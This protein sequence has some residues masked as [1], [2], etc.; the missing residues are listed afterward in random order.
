MRSAVELAH[1]CTAHRAGT[2][3]ESPTPIPA[4][5]RSICSRQIDVPVLSAGGC[6]NVLVVTGIF[7][8]D[9]GGP[10]SYVPVM[11]TALQGKGHA[12]VS[13]VT[14]ADDEAAGF[15]VECWSGATDVAG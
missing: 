13:V 1:D 4:Q 5:N 12:I 2:S 3:A 11:A 6:M 7:P 14:L 15:R 9:H 10:A 8:P